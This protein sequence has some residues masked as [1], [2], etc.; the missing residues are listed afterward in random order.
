M[1]GGLSL[2]DLAATTARFDL[3]LEAE[4][5]KKGIA[6][7]RASEETTEG[8]TSGATT[9]G[10]LDRLV[11][12]E[13]DEGARGIRGEATA[14]VPDTDGGPSPSSSAGP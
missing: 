7:P 5:D 9:V 6:R 14:T 1:A 12:E 11:Q 13:G 10:I 3:R 2:A 4:H 8:G